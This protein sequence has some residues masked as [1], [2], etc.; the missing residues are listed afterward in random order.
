MPTTIDWGSALVT[1]LYIVV[2]GIVI[3]LV[4]YFTNRQVRTIYIAAAIKTGFQANIEVKASE[5][6]TEIDEWEKKMKAEGYET[7]SGTEQLRIKHTFFQHLH[8]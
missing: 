1:L 8:R 6:K 3:F 5:N 7:K 2:F 4:L